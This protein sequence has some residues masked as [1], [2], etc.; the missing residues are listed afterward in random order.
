MDQLRLSRD[1]ARALV[2]DDTAA[3][4]RALA[5]RVPIE[6]RYFRRGDIAFSDKKI[7]DWLTDY[8]TSPENRQEDSEHQ[9]VDLWRRAEV[10]DEPDGCMHLSILAR[11]KRPPDDALEMFLV[12]PWHSPFIDVVFSHPG[13]TEERVAKIV[14]IFC[15]APDRCTRECF[16]GT[17]AAQNMHRLIAHGMV[18]NDSLIGLLKACL[19]FAIDY[20]LDNNTTHQS[21]SDV[22]NE[23]GFKELAEAKQMLGH[24]VAEL[25][26]RGHSSE[27][28][29]NFGLG[30]DV[31]LFTAPWKRRR[32]LTRD[33]VDARKEICGRLLA[34]AATCF[35]GVPR[36]FELE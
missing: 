20:I 2:A 7:R 29:L 23:E 8:F 19:Q 24:I 28:V 12:N 4:D 31:L 6:V 16:F 9:L 34:A 18:S 30:D 21:T 14:E 26:C 36:K 13:L 25:R 35:P 17:D 22:D 11:I 32:Y 15:T 1:F 3:V 10:Q 33:R 27:A 5:A